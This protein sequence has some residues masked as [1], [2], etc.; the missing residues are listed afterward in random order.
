MDTVKLKNGSE[1]AEVIVKA[2]IISLR[3]LFQNTFIAL[4]ELT[5]K[6]KNE[7]HVIFGNNADIIKGYGLCQSDESVHDS[8]KNVV[9]SAIE[10]EGLEMKL[11]SPV[12][13]H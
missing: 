6:C 1:E 9:L 7:N 3:S 8:I 5:E 10:G 4:F 13:V 2:T 11:V 12:L